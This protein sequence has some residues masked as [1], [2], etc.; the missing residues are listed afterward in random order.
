[1]KE[2]FTLAF[3]ELS[4]GRYQIEVIYPVDDP[5]EVELTGRRYKVH[6]AKIFDSKHEV[7]DYI[8]EWLKNSK[9]E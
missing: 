7:D 6:E 4:E 3:Y 9:L 2:K 1:M 5:K 8:Q